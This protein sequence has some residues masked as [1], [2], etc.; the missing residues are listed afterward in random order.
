MDRSRRYFAYTLLATFGTI[1]CALLPK[2][3]AQS[4]TPSQTIHYG[5]KKFELS[6]FVGI[7]DYAV[8]FMT[9]PQTGDLFWS[10][11]GQNEASL[12][13]IPL[14]K[15]GGSIRYDEDRAEE[16]FT[17]GRRSFWLPRFFK[18]ETGPARSG[19]LVNTDE[20]N[21][22]V[23][24]MYFYNPYKKS[25][26]QIT[27]TFYNSA[28]TIDPQTNH[29]IF[30]GRKDSQAG[31]RACLWETNVE[32]TDAALLNPKELACDSK[33]Q[34]FNVWEN[35]VLERGG[36]RIAQ[37]IES[38]LAPQKIYRGIAIYSPRSG[39]LEV[40]LPVQ[41]NRKY[42]TILSFR[43]NGIV[44]LAD[45]TDHPDK[46]GLYRLNLATQEIKPLLSNLHPDV[47]AFYDSQG[48]RVILFDLDKN[49]NTL[50]ISYD[51]YGQKVTATKAIPRVFVWLP[52]FV[53][54]LPGGRY[55]I[56]ARSLDA[57][58]PD[59]GAATFLLAIH[60]RTDNSIDLVK[61]IFRPKAIARLAKPCE[62]KPF[63][64]ESFDKLK[65]QGHIFYPP[66]KPA[67]PAAIVFAHGGPSDEV[68]AS[69]D[70][71]I[72]ALCHAGYVVAAPNVRGSRG[73]GQK[74]ED[75]NNGDHG[76]NDMKDYEEAAKFVSKSLA[77]DSRR[78]GIFGFSYG[79]FIAALAA[80]K[81]GTEGGYPWA[82]SVALGPI[83][84]QLYQLQNS[85]IGANSLMAEMGNPN[86]EADPT[87]K[88]RK[89]Y[90]DRSPVTWVD[91]LRI[92]LLVVAG[93]SD[94]RTPVAQVGVFAEKILN[95]AQIPVEVKKRFQSLKL[96]G[97][98]HPPVYFENLERE[99]QT[100][101]DFLWRNLPVTMEPAIEKN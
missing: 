20:N 31:G 67:N 57:K 54:P 21:N 48:D 60:P 64:Y 99:Y 43:D 79:G 65:I 44:F 61:E 98:G 92:P 80:T 28:Y 9:D 55:V 47:R 82:V 50:V 69:F 40:A 52:D 17:L 71:F 1:F 7:S 23:F 30:S 88:T 6:A 45:S 84:D 68:T 86:P 75:L 101:Y 77:V 78:I 12:F 18:S 76:G 89:L 87:G 24:N 73:F 42:L 5:P 74:F 96:P 51:A 93:G 63:A 58:S 81:T 19:F 83:T 10:R 34:W 70:P 27:H 49:K 25:L 41:I 32:G 62:T 16:V 56:S 100:V 36:K 2:I 59:G 37:V 13:R 95:S 14:V 53:Q 22:E 97:E 29:L 72:Q 33:T 66:S 94:A 3:F 90:V 11:N 39:R 35:P 26:R 38:Q 15:D 4:R 91:Q 46:R 8:R 85:S